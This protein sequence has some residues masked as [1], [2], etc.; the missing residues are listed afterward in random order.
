MASSTK[1]TLLEQVREAI[2]VGRLPC[3]PPARSWGGRGTGAACAICGEQIGPN[4]LEYELEFAR[5][6]STQGQAGI[7]VHLQCWSTWE[8]ERL[9]VQSTG[10]THGR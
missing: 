2:E 8:L 4:Q 3:Q 1:E 10:S 7:H 9:A 6:G 5:A